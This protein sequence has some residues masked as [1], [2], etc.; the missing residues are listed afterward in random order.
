M[1]LGNCFRLY[2]LKLKLKLKLACNADSDVHLQV[3]LAHRKVVVMHQQTL[4]PSSAHQ[5]K[6]LP[7][8]HPGRMTSTCPLSTTACPTSTFSPEAFPQ[9]RLQLPDNPLRVR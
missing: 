8:M 4:R 5:S 3:Q 6:T 1:V 2:N 9:L 7:C